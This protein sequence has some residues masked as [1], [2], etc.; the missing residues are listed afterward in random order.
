M[1]DQDETSRALSKDGGGVEMTAFPSASVAG[2][3][4]RREGGQTSPS[5][6]S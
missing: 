2:V 5:K 6:S 3:A 1:S 4:S